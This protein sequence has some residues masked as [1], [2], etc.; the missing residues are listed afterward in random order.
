VKQLIV[1]NV[2]INIASQDAGDYISLTDIARIRNVNEPKDVVKNW[3]RTRAPLNTLVY[4]KRLITPALKGS[5]S[6]PL[7][8]K[9]APTA[10]RYRPRV[11]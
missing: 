11:G 3:L 5:N 9:Q 1:Q 4:G 7:N 2:V 8:N 10:S 6:T